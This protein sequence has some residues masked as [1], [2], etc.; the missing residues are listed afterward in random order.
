[1]A[2]VLLGDPCSVVVW[3]TPITEVGR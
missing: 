2:L 1:V 3:K